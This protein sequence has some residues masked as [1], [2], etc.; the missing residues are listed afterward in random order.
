M[1]EAWATPRL[2]RVTQEPQRI[3][4]GRLSQTGEDAAHALSMWVAGGL[5]YIGIYRQGGKFQT[6]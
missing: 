3:I 6:K 4:H 2:S 1:G 5:H